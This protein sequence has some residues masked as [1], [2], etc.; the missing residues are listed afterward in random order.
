MFGSGAIEMLAREMSEDLIA[1]RESARAE[2]AASGAP[3]TRDLE[4]KGVS[5]GRITLLPNGL[6]D[7]SAIEGID[8]DLIVKPFHQI[9]T[10]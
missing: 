6:V 3:V 10:T 2:A 8:W 9:A 4:A 5:F 1:I 7:P